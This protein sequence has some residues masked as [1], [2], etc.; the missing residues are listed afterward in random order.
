VLEDDEF[1]P[2]TYQKIPYHMVFDVKF[3]LGRK[4]Q[5]VAG[6]TGLSLPRKMYIQE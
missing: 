6:E 4:A 2:K 3:D 1:L 5:L